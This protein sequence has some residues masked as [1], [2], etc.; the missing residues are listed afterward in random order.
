MARIQ[1]VDGRSC[2]Q[3]Q[4]ARRRASGS[5]LEIDAWIPSETKA[6][7]PLLDRL[8]RLIEGSRCVPGEEPAVER[9][10]REALNNAVVHGPALPLPLAAGVVYRGA[11]RGR[12]SN[13]RRFDSDD[14]S[15]STVLRPYEPAPTARSGTKY[16]LGEQ[17]QCPVPILSCAETRP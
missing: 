7:S 9:A 10:L 4:F 3:A 11:L 2:L 12:E 5:L 16:S 6:V 8:M 15:A 14:A 1:T 13:W 17:S